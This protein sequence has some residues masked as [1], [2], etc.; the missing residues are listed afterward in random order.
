MNFSELTA[1][2]LARQ[3]RSKAISA[4]EA[5]Q[6]SLRRI[7]ALDTRVGAF[8]DVHAEQ[9]I[10]Q[11][12]SVDER[13]AAGVDP[14]P[15]AGVPIAV[16]DNICTMDRPT[17]CASKILANYRP[18][19]NAHVVEQLHRAGAVILGK[20][21]LD[22]FAMGSS[23]E[24]SAVKKTRNPFNLDCV[25][26]GSSGGSAA[27][28]SARLT[29]IALGSDTGGSIRLPASFCGVCGFK[30]TYGRVS[31]YGLIAYGS[32]L[33][34]I[35]PFG[36]D[37]ED[38]ALV[39]NAIAGHDRRD[40]TSVPDS[41]AT[42][43][44]FCA[45]LDQSIEGLR[46]GL[47]K[48]FF[49]QKG[50]DAEVAKAV[51]EAI[52]VLKTLGADVVEV[53]LPTTDAAVACYYLIAT[54]EAS[55]NLARFDGVHYGHRTAC[56]ENIDDVYFLSRE[57]GF[58]EE[59][60]RRIMLGTY[61]LSAGYYDAYY[62][63][64]LKVRTLIRQDFEKAFKKVDVICCPVSP[65]PAFRIGERSADPLTMYLSDIYTIAVNLAGIAGLSIPCGVTS[66]GLPIG[67]QTL[68]R[69]FDDAVVLQTGWA[70]Q[71]ETRW[72]RTLPAVAREA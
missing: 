19:Y 71:S 14:G 52:G 72:H 68:G 13:L 44:D 29:P 27:A 6:E 28:V 1:G 3:I 53:S 58:G 60:K 11:A 65:T 32:S 38:I 26:G 7:E 25:P 43:P 18:P 24:N 30:P 16:K 55:S 51:D 33:D 15:L 41:Y 62:L 42:Y 45:G 21:N 46:I 67:L 70:Y 31:R 61:V 34:Q 2:E 59:V 8:L 10:H 66:A 5:T 57:E 49:G 50:L 23:T 47:P 39:M 37:V 69:S 36:V 63:K 20:T 22:E 54:A 48:E 35:G 56:P 12:R 17:T 64:A 9:A 4:V 40:S